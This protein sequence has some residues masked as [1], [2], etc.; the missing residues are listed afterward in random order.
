[1]KKTTLIIL[2]ALL[3]KGI[4]MA[5]Q[6]PV[7]TQYMF[8]DFVINP[9]VAGTYNYYQ[10][11]TCHRVQW[12]GI[13]DAPLTN[14]ISAYGP[15]SSK[16]MGFGG[17]IYNDITGPTS[18]T[19]LTGTF[20]YNLPITSDIRV[21]MGIAPSLIQYKFDFTK[22]TFQESDPKYP[23]NVDS[24]IAFDAAFGVYV[25]TGS[26]QIGFAAHH[27]IPNKLKLGEGSTVATNLTRLKTNFYLT[28]AY[29][30][31]INKRWAVEPS[32]LLKSMAVSAFQG[33]FSCRALYKSTY[34]G[35]LSWRTGDAIAVLGGILYQ[36]K[37][38]LGISYDITASKMGIS[39][40]GGSLEVM[41][42]Y[43]FNPVK[44]SS[45]KK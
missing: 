16:P 43:K 23:S 1:M 17:M 20:A 8:N 45:K 34:W 31:F 2:L 21:S 25:W 3:A 39:R 32:V 41:L 33:E 7:Y 40:T 26:Y 37:Y 29:K 12:M 10:I 30:Y 5:Q 22:T 19:Y 15:H 9:A 6:T 18:Y 27:L 11:R 44:N 28:G 35:G 4:L 13:P 14:V 24:K 38:F 36:N 42:G